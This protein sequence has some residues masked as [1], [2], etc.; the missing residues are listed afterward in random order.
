MSDDEDVIVG[1]DPGRPLKNPRDERFCIAF[2]RCSSQTE[3]VR[4]AGYD[5]KRPAEKGRRLLQRIDVKRRIEWLQGK[6]ADKMTED[7]AVTREWVRS[8]LR[9][10]VEVA[11]TPQPVLDRS[12]EPTGRIHRD[13]ASANKALELLGKEQG[14]FVDRIRTEGTEAEIEGMGTEQLEALI[15]SY[16]ADIGP[17][18]V[19]R[20][21]GDIERE[22]DDGGPD[23]GGNAPTGEGSGGPAPESSEPVPTVSEAGGI[24]SSRV[25]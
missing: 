6:V 5:H 24:P 17:Q 12:G 22:S 25:H 7:E 20:L 10:N 15:K 14:M 8:E 2:V 3:A 16:I 19:R 13:L 11:K 21:L 1:R 18:T 9:H 4:E 23:A